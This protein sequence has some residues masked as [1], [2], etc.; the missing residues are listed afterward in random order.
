[1][2]F[3]DSSNVT[4]IK[5]FHKMGIIRGVTTNPTIMKKDGNTDTEARLKRAILKIRPLLQQLQAI[6]FQALSTTT[7]KY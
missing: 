3:L 7:T 4:E 5:R 2:I 1:M 6:R